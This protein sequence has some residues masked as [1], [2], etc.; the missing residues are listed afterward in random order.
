MGRLDHLTA[1]GNALAVILQSSG[2]YESEAVGGIRREL[3]NVVEISVVVESRTL[4]GVLSDLEGTEYNVSSIVDTDDDHDWIIRGEVATADAEAPFVVYCANSGE[5]DSFVWFYTGS[6]AEI[7]RLQEEAI[8]QGFVSLD[9]HGLDDGV[10]PV[11]A[12][13]DIYSDL[14]EVYV[15]P[16]DR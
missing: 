6:P 11:V 1:I 4:S 10:S 7:L 14:G 2:T 16:E 13:E 5:Y 8:A 3:V 9:M 15:E 12:E